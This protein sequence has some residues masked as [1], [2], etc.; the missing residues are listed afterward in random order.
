M[1]E[2]KPKSDVSAGDVVVQGDLVC[3]V[4]EP[5]KKGKPGCLL[6]GGRFLFSKPVG[7]SIKRGSHLYWNASTDMVSTRID[8]GPYLGRAIKRAVAAAETVEAVLSPGG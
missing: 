3:V 1:K 7:L 5:I 6:Y 4:A 2:M 8:D